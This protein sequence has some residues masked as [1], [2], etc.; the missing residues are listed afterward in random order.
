MDAIDGV[1]IYFENPVRDDR[2]GL[3]VPEPGCITLDSRNA[4]GFVRSRAYQEFVDGRWRTDPTGDLGRIRR[5]QQFIIAALERSVDR[6]LRNPVTLD[7]LIDSALEAVTIDDTLDGDDLLALGRAF[8]R[9][10]PQSL[11]VLEMPVEDDTRRGCR[12]PAA[13]HPG[14]R[15]D[16]RHLP[17]PR[18]GGGA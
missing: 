3:S 11:D 14:G 13:R 18:C 7:E 5:Q 10:D 16:P 12:G 15:P 2:S 9:F 8:R 6:G 1:Q 4:L 17:H